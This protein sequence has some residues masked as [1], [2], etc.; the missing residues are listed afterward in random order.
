MSEE[1]VRRILAEYIPP[2][3][4]AQVDKLAKDILDCVQ[5]QKQPEK[6]GKA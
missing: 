5:S 3:T 1:A 2:L 6:K 4:H